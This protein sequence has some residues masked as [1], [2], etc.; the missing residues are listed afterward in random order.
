[1]RQTP[2]VSVCSFGLCSFVNGSTSTH[3]SGCVVDGPS[4]MAIEEVSLLLASGSAH[5][6]VYIP[7]K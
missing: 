3:Y 6:S 5:W 4:T 7:H 1:M 2:G